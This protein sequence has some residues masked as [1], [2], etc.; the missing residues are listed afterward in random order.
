M[1]VAFYAPM[2][3]PDDPVPSGDRTIGRLFMRALEFAG[4]QPEIVC[5]F[6]SR[7]GG[8]DAARQ[9]RIGSVGLRLAG[10][11]AERIARRPVDRQPRAW[12]TYHVYHK[13]PDWLG[14]AVAD[15]LDI[16]YLIAEASSA[17]K[18]AGGRWDHGYR[19]ANDAIARADAV[20]SLNSDD[21]NCLYPLV[22]QP[23]LMRRLWPFIE[24]APFAAAAERRAA[25]R[26]DLARRHA[27]DPAKP[28]LLAV[29]MM[30]P[31]D[32]EASYRRLAA[33]LARLAGRDW[34]LLVAG[35]GPARGDIVRTLEAA[36]PGRPRH[37]GLVPEGELPAL[38]AACDLLTWPA[39]REAFGMALVEA[40]AAGLPVVACA[41]RGVPDV[42]SAG[43]SGLLPAPDDDAAFAAAVAR[44]LDDP[45]RRAEMGRVARRLATE[46]HDIA[47]AAGLLDA[48]LAV[49]RHKRL[50]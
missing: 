28:W 42:V 41:T 12:L 18:Q 10:H 38:Y 8:G 39:V 46:R 49:L 44:L 14:P 26:A 17:P 6:R 16:P 27:L 4:H 47:Y 30:R 3:A 37:L 25:H 34:T 7:D 48:T 33:A 11:I 35:D 23:V 31:G 24:T 22:R 21:L 43:V 32:K 1:R 5:R 13:A 50:N 29:G 40:Q 15:A 19:A 36:I 2:K 45:A 9:A 20:L